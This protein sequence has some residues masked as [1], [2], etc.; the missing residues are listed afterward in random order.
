MSH[1]GSNSR[2]IASP[3]GLLWCVAGGC[4]FGAARC[5]VL[6][7]S[8]SEPLASLAAVG[9]MVAALYGSKMALRALHAGDLRRD[10]RAMDRARRSSAHTHGR[11][12]LATA[13]DAARFGLTG[14]SGVFLGA[15]RRSSRRSTDLFYR[16]E[17]HVLTIGPAGSGKGTC[18]V[19]P[20]L[21]LNRE[22]M[23]V[24]DVKGELAAMTAR[25]R[26][27]QLGHRVVLLNP[28]HVT[29]SEELGIALRDDGYNPFS[30]LR[31]GPTAKDDAELL[32][33]L[34]LPMPAKPDPKSEFFIDAGQQIVT[35]GI[36]D[37]LR[38]GETPTAP[39]LRQ[40]LMASPETFERQLADMAFTTAFGGVLA[41]AGRKLLGTLQ[42][43]PEEFQG[44]LSTAQ[45]A[46]RIYDGF[47]PLGEHV[48]RGDGFTFSSMKDRPTTVYITLPSDR[49]ITHAAWM[50]LVLSS[51]IELVGRDR[52]NKR[53]TFLMDE[54]ANLGYLPN[55]LRAMAQYRAQGVRV[56][57]V[58]QQV[59]QIRRIYGVEGWRDLVGLCDVV[60]TVS[61]AEYETT[62]LLSDMTGHVTVED[63]GQ[64]VRPMSAGGTSHAEF[65]F[66]QSR[67]G[68]PLLRPE[69]I[70]LLDSDMQ[71]I[72][73]RNMPPL[74][75][76][77]VDYR[78]RRQWHSW[79]DPN[80]YYSRRPGSSGNKEG[81]T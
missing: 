9:C 59:S 49:G 41:E 33:S 6:S 18:V 48:S 25:H 14:S 22:S 11:A 78:T 26:R 4:W 52:T 13:K 50:S 77:K 28:F 16:G 37:L 63:V 2:V 7:R 79:A 34:L 74:L 12:R 65:S 55:L 44:G 15:I 64:S 61:S 43:A 72:F 57:A 58:I 38:T 21:L 23:V 73:Y 67:T 75:A 20:N 27:E 70:R 71:L 45:K 29:L 80:P 32:A 5:D 39:R 8:L 68:Q 3:P 76:R 53:V 47:G 40:W 36:L 60:Q 81:V 24:V 10:H 31:R 30:L 69:D 54:L 42:N 19:V 1:A 56:H 51:A 66:G 46:L 17:N 62:R 35:A